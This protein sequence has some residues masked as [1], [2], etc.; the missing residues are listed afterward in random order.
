MKDFRERL[1]NTA[2]SMDF[3]SI[4]P[5]QQTRIDTKRQKKEERTSSWEEK[6]LHGQSVQQTKEVG[7][8]DSWEYL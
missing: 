7:N 4:D 2:R 8:Q 3:D 6:M 1:L 5:V